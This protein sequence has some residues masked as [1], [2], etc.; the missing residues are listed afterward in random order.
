MT[1]AE[2]P[3]DELERQRL[4]RVAALVESQRVIAE[5]TRARA[6]KELRDFGTGDQG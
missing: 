1:E 6:E 5:A 4:A 2:N 3:L